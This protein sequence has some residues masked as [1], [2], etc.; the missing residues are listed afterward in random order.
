MWD[1]GNADSLPR[2]QRDS[3]KERKNLTYL[4][5]EASRYERYY[6]SPVCSIQ[7]AYNAKLR[8]D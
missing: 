2:G 5:L 3:N 1:E 7:L 8:E 6:G 4:A